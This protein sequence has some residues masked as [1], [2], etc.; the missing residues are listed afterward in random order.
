MY[1]DQGSLKKSG[2]LQKRFIR[3]MC[4]ILALVVAAQ[5]VAVHLAA[6][7]VVKHDGEARHATLN[8]ARTEAVYCVLPTQKTRY[9]SPAQG[10]LGPVVRSHISDLAQLG[11][12]H[13]HGH[14]QCGLPVAENSTLL[15]LN[16]MLNV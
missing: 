2:M 11:R 13:H 12:P 15:A 1:D 16:C 4:C 3:F 10:F 8:S 7:S 14:S 6:D 5:G 9:A